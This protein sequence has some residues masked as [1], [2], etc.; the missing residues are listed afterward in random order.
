MLDRLDPAD[1]REEIE[2]SIADLQ[3]A[4]LERPPFLAYPHGAFDGG[5][6]AVAKQA[7]LAGAFTTRAGLARPGV[8]PFA[9]PRIEIFRRDGTIRFAW[10]VVT[11][12]RLGR[13]GS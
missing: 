7:G 1:V 6:Q 2:E 10:K 12:R 8:D 11:G 3:R 13:P 5:V 9:L 4:G